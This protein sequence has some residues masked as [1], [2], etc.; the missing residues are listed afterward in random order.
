MYR[1][2]GKLFLDRGVIVKDTY[3]LNIGGDTD[4]ENM[5]KE[6]RLT[7]KRKSKTAAVTSVLP[8]ET[9]CR[10]GP[11]DFRCLSYAGKKF[12]TFG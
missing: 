9:K 6:S 11:L 5:K 10:I 2:L 3:Q 7:T 4:F 12:A 8:Y 1:M